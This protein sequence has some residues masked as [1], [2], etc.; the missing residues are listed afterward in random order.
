MHE[1]YYLFEACCRMSNY[2]FM[3]Q[4]YNSVPSKHMYKEMIRIQYYKLN[5]HYLILNV[6]DQLKSSMRVQDMKCP[7]M[8]DKPA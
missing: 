8:F 2:I 6:F 5:A 3:A 7:V 1:V 4:D